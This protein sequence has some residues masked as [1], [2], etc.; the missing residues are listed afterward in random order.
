M[1]RSPELAQSSEDAWST[2]RGVRSDDAD[3]RAAESPR[4]CCSSAT[5][6]AVRSAYLCRATDASEISDSTRRRRP[7]R[8]EARVHWRR[9]PSS[10]S[11]W[12]SFSSPLARAW[13]GHEVVDLAVGR[14]A[15]HDAEE[16]PDEVVAALDDKTEAVIQSE[17]ELRQ[18]LDLT[19]RR[20]PPP[21]RRGRRMPA[22]A[23]G[24]WS[25]CRALVAS[26]ILA[27]SSHGAWDSVRSHSGADARA[28]VQPNAALPEGVSHNRISVAAIPPPSPTPPPIV[29]PG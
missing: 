25:Q 3:H 4:L 5:R 19:P 17:R 26:G 13:D 16:N 15:L 28:S 14:L 12:T 18:I 20:N 11:S 1:R 21:R 29:K 8:G 27:S 6:P 7:G 2:P 22:F 23:A 10:S 9:C 24:T